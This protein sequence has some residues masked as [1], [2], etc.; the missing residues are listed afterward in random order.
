MSQS[1]IDIYVYA[2]WQEI[3]EPNLIGILSAQQAKGKKAFSFEYDTNWLKTEQKFLLDPDIQ[4]YGDPQYPNQKKPVA[5][6]FPNITKTSIAILSK[7]LFVNSINIK[8][9]VFKRYFLILSLEI[10][11]KNNYNVL[12]Y[13]AT[14]FY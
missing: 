1:K 12:L 5:F 6:F 10:F 4:L 11:S 2:H 7:N 9:I 8:P 14:C 3:Q 13:S